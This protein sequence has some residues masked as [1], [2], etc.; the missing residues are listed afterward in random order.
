MADLA[1]S[2]ENPLAGVAEPGKGRVSSNFDDEKQHVMTTVEHMHNHRRLTSRQIQLLAIAGTIGKSGIWNESCHVPSSS[3][4]SRFKRLTSALSIIAYWPQQVLHC[5]S[6]SVHHWQM[7]DLSVYCLDSSSGASTSGVWHNAR[8]KW[9]RFFR[10]MV[11]SSASPDASST[12][13]GEWQQAT[14]VSLIAID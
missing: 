11:P 10:S 8:S 12:N 5:S 6:V 2:K 14:T 1:A 3:I 13:L 7:A 9:S 4:T